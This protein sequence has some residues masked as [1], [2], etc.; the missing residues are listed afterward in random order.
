MRGRSGRADLL[1]IVPGAR[2]LVRD[3]ALTQLQARIFARQLL[4]PAPPDHA[5]T[6]R[7]EDQQDPSTIR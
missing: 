4:Y 7:D 1:L 2:V 5:A 6:Q 3:R